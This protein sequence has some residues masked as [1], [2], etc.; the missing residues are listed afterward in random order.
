MGFCFLRRRLLETAKNRL[1]N[2]EFT[3]RGLATAIGVSQPQIHHILKGERGLTVETADRLLS[4]LEISV[5][6]L[7]AEPINRSS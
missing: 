3:E 4:Q 6:E 5:T 1:A 7:L 2:G